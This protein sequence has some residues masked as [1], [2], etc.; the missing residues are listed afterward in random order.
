MPLKQLAADF[1][2][3]VTQIPRQHRLGTMQMP[4]RCSHTPAFGNR[5]DVAKL[6]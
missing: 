3:E 2:L 1:P 6:I 5:H 4:C